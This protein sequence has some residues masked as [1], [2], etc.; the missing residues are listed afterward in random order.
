MPGRHLLLA[1]LALLQAAALGACKKS[2]PSEPAGGPAASASSFVLPAPVASGIPTPTRDISSVVNPKGEPPYTGPAGKV[3]GRVRVTGDSAPELPEAVRAISD[4]CAPAREVYGKAFREGVDRAL[5]DVLVGV[6]GY[7]GYVPPASSVVKV[8]AA[9]CAWSA[10][11]FALT[12]GQ[13]IDVEAKDRKAYIP[14]LLGARMPA[15]LVALP[16]GSGSSLYPT[17]PGR[18]VLVDS[19]RIFSRAEVLVLKYATHDVTGLDGRFTI[20]GIPAGKVTLSAYFPAT[21]QMLDREVVIPAGGTLEQD[22]EFAFN[23]KAFAEAQE[24]A[25]SESASSAKSSASAASPPA[26]GSSAPA[27][28]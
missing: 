24:R 13:R 14:D 9:G 21:G 23:A 3:T 18:Y 15:Q 22:L 2:S 26:S 12:F 1:L 27:R 4:E 8:P 28:K 16:G 25:R 6:T 19:L 20:S 7:S 10:R 17:S 11:T 5:A